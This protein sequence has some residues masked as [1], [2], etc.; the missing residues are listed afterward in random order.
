MAAFFYLHI[1]RSGRVRL[2]N[3]SCELACL[4]RCIPMRRH[5]LARAGAACRFG[6]PACSVVRDLPDYST[7]AFCFNASP[8]RQAHPCSRIKTSATVLMYCPAM[9]GADTTKD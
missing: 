4:L 9:T 1:A 7:P 8:A 5:K 2:R 6:L 3:L